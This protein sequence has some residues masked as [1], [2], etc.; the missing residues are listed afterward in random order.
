MPVALISENESELLNLSEEQ[1][2]EE[3]EESAEME[4]IDERVVRVEKTKKQDYSSILDQINF[5]EDEDDDQ[6]QTDGEIVIKAKRTHNNS[7]YDSSD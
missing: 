6:D 1:P 4:G 3:E 5:S 7:N 2:F